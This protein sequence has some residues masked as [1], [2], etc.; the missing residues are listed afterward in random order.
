MQKKA[1]ESFL[2]N[3]AN[4]T[5]MMTRHIMRELEIIKHETSNLNLGYA[6]KLDTWKLS[7]PRE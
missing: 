1:H 5:S 3:V 2:N 7:Y 4:N 6:A